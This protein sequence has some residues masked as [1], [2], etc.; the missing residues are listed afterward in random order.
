MTISE[1]ILRRR[2]K[3]GWRCF[4]CDE[5]F[6]SSAAAEKHFGKRLDGLPLCRVGR[7]ELDEMQEQLSR[8]RNEDTD[9]HRRIAYLEGTIETEKRRANEKG[10]ADGLRDGRRLRVEPP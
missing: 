3:E 1:A 4:H 2:E 8:Y 6:H 5:V 7:K 9:L 10:Y